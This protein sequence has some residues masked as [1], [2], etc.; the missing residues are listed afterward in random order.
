[1]EVRRF[2]YLDRPD[3]AERLEQAESGAFPEFLLHD[4]VW[5]D[6]W[7]RVVDAFAE[8]HYALVDA[9]TGELL[10]GTNAVAFHWDGTLDDL[11]N[12]THAALLRS[13]AEH[14]SRLAPNTICGI[15]SIAVDEARG[16]GLSDEF[17]RAG[18]ER[19]KGFEHAVTPLRVLL[20][21]R[22]PLAPLDEYI[23]WRRRDGGWFDP[24]LRVWLRAGARVLKV[25]PDSI[26]IEAALEEWEE[27]LGMELPAS[28]QYIIPGGHAPLTVDRDKNVARYAEPHVWIELAW[29][30]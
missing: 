12:G 25:S 15:Q 19:A 14:E 8:L 22:Y 16:Q 11:P 5:N 4:S 2:S 7:P 3:L 20:K 1:L 30:D 21:D 17:V 23:T 26:V 13:L 24:W 27:W 9:E 29:R 10:G 18:R 6:C 28:G